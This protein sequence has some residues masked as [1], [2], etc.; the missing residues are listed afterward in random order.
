MSERADDRRTATSQ[1]NTEGPGQRAPGLR[2]CP[3]YAG[4]RVAGEL[5]ARRVPC[6]R[7]V[8]LTFLPLCVF[9]MV[10]NSTFLDT[11]SLTLSV[12][13]L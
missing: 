2:N 6:A 9:Y 12:F 11:S 5:P 10:I 13:R 1:S 4:V 7:S 8:I 3:R